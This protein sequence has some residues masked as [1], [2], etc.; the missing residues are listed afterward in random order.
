MNYRNLLIATVV[1]GLFA[2]GCGDDSSG[3]DSGFEYRGTDLCLGT[4]DSMLVESHLQGGA[5]VP[6]GGLQHPIELVRECAIGSCYDEIFAETGFDECIQACME[7]TTLSGLTPSCLGCFTDFVVC[8]QEFCVVEC[9]NS[10]GPECDD[11]LEA[12]CLPGE[13]DCAGIQ[14]L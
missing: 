3:D 11:C 5:G 6:D 13:R 9:L 2:A 1:A 10:D 12:H 8:A 7:S 14:D 4:S